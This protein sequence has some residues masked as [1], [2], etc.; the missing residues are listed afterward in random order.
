MAPQVTTSKYNTIRFAL[1]LIAAGLVL[2]LLLMKH[3]QITNAQVRDFRIAAQNA[4]VIQSAQANLTN[5]CGDKEMTVFSPTVYICNEPQNELIY[6][7]I[8][9]LYP[10]SASGREIMYSFIDE[11]DRERADEMLSNIYHIQRYDP[12]ILAPLTWT[13]DPFDERYWRFLFYSLRPVRHLLAT[14]EETRSERYYEKTREIIGSFVDSGMDSPYAWDDPHSAAFRTMILINAWWKL[15]EAGELPADLSDKILSALEVHGDYLLDPENYEGDH[16][17]AV[18]QSAAL[19][20]VA[21]NFPELANAETWR[22][23]AIRRIDVGLS[24][25]IDPNGVLI[26][27]SPYYQFYVLEKYWEIYQYAE[28]NSIEISDNFGDTIEKMIGFSTYVLR[29]DVSVP[30]LGASSPRTFVRSGVYDYITDENKE[31]AFVLSRGKEG[32]RPTETAVLYPSSGL[33]IFRSG[34][35]E[36]RAFEDEAYLIYDTGPYRT[37]HSHYDALTFSVFA[38]QVPIIRDAGLFTYEEDHPFYIYFHGT[39]GHNTVMVDGQ[40][41]PEGT[42]ERKR[43]M[44]GENFASLSAWHGLYD[45]VRHSRAIALLGSNAVLVVDNLT[46]DGKHTYEQLFHLSPDVTITSKNPQTLR[47]TVKEN[48]QSVPFTIQQLLP[49]EQ[50][51]TW[52]GQED[53]I[54]GYCAVAYEI[55]T[56][57]D[58]LSYQIIDSS[59]RYITLITFGEDEDSLQSSYDRDKNQLAISNQ[60]GTFV[61]DISFPNHGLVS[62]PF[63]D[64]Q[65]QS[66]TTGGPMIERAQRF[67]R[68]LFSTS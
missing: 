16:N 60:S 21:E 7:D 47:G 27:N 11:G 40:D 57:C 5:P 2:V 52:R 64:L 43:V 33:A 15:R 38:Y 26:E 28:E 24:S 39:R 9:N 31:F 30:L 48:G 37:D 46:A 36:D 42:A 12:V 1:L 8:Y 67:F 4:V 61:V 49:V 34:W 10:A 45:G 54:R 35:G 56:A 59:A 32:R 20:L 51:S 6:A 18:T 41:Q 19:L 53:P 55:S 65:I 58:E 66:E 3:Y 22:E 25:I 62:S 13:E 68:T 14:A 29:P 17:H 23:A 44:K 50:L 63:I